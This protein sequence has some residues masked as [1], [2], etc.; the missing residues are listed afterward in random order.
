MGVFLLFAV[1]SSI[2]G[3]L[4]ATTRRIQYRFGI[5][6]AWHLSGALLLGFGFAGLRPANYRLDSYWILDPLDRT[7]VGGVTAGLLLLG[8]WAAFH[9]ARA[10]VPENGTPLIRGAVLFGNLCL[11]LAVYFTAWLLTP[12]LYYLYYRLIFANLP[13]QWVIH[14]GADALIFWRALLLSPEGSIAATVAGLYFW[15]IFAL[16]VSIHAQSWRTA[17]RTDR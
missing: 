6:S 10:L 5:L 1:F 2:W 9:A 3:V 13:Q 4:P 14:S 11:T 12:Q 15:L 17:P 8:S 16:T 7:V